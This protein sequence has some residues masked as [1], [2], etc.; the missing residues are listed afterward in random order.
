ML[1][2]ALRPDNCSML[3]R[4]LESRTKKPAVHVSSVWSYSVAATLG[5]AAFFLTCPAYILDPTNLA[6]VYPHRDPIYYAPDYHTHY[7]GWLFLRHSP[8]SFPLG[9]IP[10]YVA[11]LPTFMAYTDSIPLAAFPLKLISDILPEDFQYLGLWTLMCFVL[12][13]LFAVRL[14]RPWIKDKWCFTCAV[15]LVTLSPI[16]IFRSFHV[17]LMSHW[18]LLWSLSVVQEY[19]LAKKRQDQVSTPL[20]T[21]MTI[22]GMATLIQPY[23]AA[24]VAGICWAM[25]LGRAL[26][27]WKEPSNSKVRIISILG[28]TTFFYIIPMAILLYAFGFLNGPSGTDGFH[29]FGTDVF[30]IFNNYGTSSFMPK[31]RDRKGLYEGYAWLGLGGWTLIIASMVPRIRTQIRVCIKDPYVKALI[32]TSLIMW[33]FALSENIHFAG[34]WLIDMEWFWKPFR[35]ITSSLRTSGRFI[36]PL[37]YILFF[38]AAAIVANQFSRKS[39]RILF[40]VALILQTID[41][42]PWMTNR[43]SRFYVQRGERL[44][45]PFWDNAASKFKKVKMIP[46]LQDVGYC[47]DKKAENRVFYEWV[48][49]ADFA[50]KNKMSINSGYLARYDKKLSTLYCGAEVYEFLTGPLQPDSL[51]IVRA[52]YTDNMPTSG[53]DRQ[54]EVHDGYT[55]CFAKMNT[56]P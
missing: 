20:R 46:P 3:G 12:Q 16:L 49:F 35:F 52:A 36:W 25:P 42:G 8:W 48:E 5:I 56:Q 30:S 9:S 14:L 28:F 51:Y 50:A 11:P 18:L 55:A 6:W 37:Y 19:I 2:F 41:L 38:G 31:F 29:Y 44:Q 54:C 24:M 43:K 47:Q 15:L 34:F 21:P 10:N 53:L 33:F 26:S 40:T 1:A 39:M 45:D 7:L 27:E 4:P 23:L 17:A 22:I 13:A 32:T